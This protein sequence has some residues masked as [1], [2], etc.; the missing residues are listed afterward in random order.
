MNMQ[1]IGTKR[2]ISWKI[3]GYTESGDEVT[4]TELPDDVAMIVDEFLNEDLG[5]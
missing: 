5:R 1:T 3:V 4:I 2:F